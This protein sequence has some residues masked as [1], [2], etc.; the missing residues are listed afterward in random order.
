M[1]TT[2]NWFIYKIS[3]KAERIHALIHYRLWA[4]FQMHTTK[5]FLYANTTLNLI[6]PYSIHVSS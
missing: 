3:T 1:D 6:T 5:C 2:I 4:F